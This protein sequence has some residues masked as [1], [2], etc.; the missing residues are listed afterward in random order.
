MKIIA[1]M[2]ARLDKMSNESRLHAPIKFGN[3]H[4]VTCLFRPA[5]HNS[6]TL[7]GKKVLVHSTADLYCTP[8]HCK[9]LPNEICEYS[10]PVVKQKLN[11]KYILKT[12]RKNREKK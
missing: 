2:V 10:P 7:Y 1:C 9:S 3:N 8:L 6:A 12:K 4:S 11:K 5:Q